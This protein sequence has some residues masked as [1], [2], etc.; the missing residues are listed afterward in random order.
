[1]KHTISNAIRMRLERVR[2][3]STPAT[4]ATRIATDQTVGVMWR[5]C[6]YGGAEP[7]VPA[8]SAKVAAE[9]SAAL[10]ASLDAVFACR[11]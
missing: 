4:T 11:S 8:A 10:Y 6:R 3:A 5:A 1:M 9:A 7:R 2:S